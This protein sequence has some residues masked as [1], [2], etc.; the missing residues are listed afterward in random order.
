MIKNYINPSSDK[1]FKEFIENP[2]TIPFSFLYNG[3]KYIGFGEEFALVDK[4]VSTENETE[5]AFF[6]FTLENLTVKAKIK[7]Y[8]THGATDFTF[9]FENNSNENTG[10]IE[11]PHF[12]YEFCG[13][14]PLLKGIYGDHHNY[15]MPYCHDFREK[16]IE[17]KQTTG[18]ATEIFFPYYNVEYGNCGTM[19]AIGWGGTWCANFQRTENGV[20]FKGNS[21]NDFKAYLK[22]GEKIRTALFVMADYTVRDEDYATNYWRDWFLKYNTPKA[23]ANGDDLEPFT[24]AMLSYDTGRVNSDGSISE[25]YTTWK[26]SLDAIIKENI[27]VDYRWVDAGWYPHPDGSSAQSYVPGYDWWNCVGTWVLDQNKWPGDTFKQSVDYGHKH[28]IKTFLWFEP[29]RTNDVENMV[30][31][32]G[33]KKEWAIDP[34][35]MP[36]L[37]HLGNHFYYGADVYHDTVTDKEVKGTL[38]NLGNEECRKYTTERICKILKENNID[39][40]REDR[41]GTEPASLWHHRDLNVEGENRLG[42]TESKAVDG[43]YKMWDDIIACTASYSGATFIDN[44]S[45][46]G[47]RLDIESMRR[48]IPVMRSDFDRTTIGVRLSI[49]STFNKWI[50][51]HGSSTREAEGE[52]TKS[53]P[54]DRYISRASLLPIFNIQSP[55]AHHPTGDFSELKRSTAEWRRINKYLLKDFY[56]LTDWHHRFNEKEFTAFSYFDPEEEKG[57]ILAFRQEKCEKENLTVNLLFLEDKA[58]YILTDEDTKETYTLNGKELSLYF[59]NPRSEKLIFIEKK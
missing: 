3:K 59:E 20:L 13:E 16:E 11:N 47:S 10:V 15:Y 28:G 35:D 50:P 41:N 4:I 17:F 52:H 56:V 30:K 51:F 46:G 2:N 32:H 37:V 45:S 39:F 19:L 57:I 23:N 40:Y 12:V 9:F 38:N 5:T 49:S 27:D 7:H 26:P 53:K 48:S 25:D 31:N 42:I 36:G 18:K 54:L 34:A 8:Y 43:H 29:E 21:V 55:F 44:C 33:Y 1:Q 14:K 6:T 22:P 58:E 24:T